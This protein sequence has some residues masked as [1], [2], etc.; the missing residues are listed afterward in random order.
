[1]SAD[2]ELG[3]DLSRLSDQFVVD[4]DNPWPGPPA[5]TESQAEFFRGRAEEAEHLLD[6]TKDAS[7]TLLYGKSG[8]GKTSLLQAGLF[9][10]LRREG[11][12]P[13]YKRLE[14]AREEDDYSKQILEAVISECER[15]EIRFKVPENGESL[16]EYFDP[17]QAEFWSPKGRPL[18]PVIVLDQFEELFTRGLGADPN[19]YEQFTN[20]L[21]ELIE[22]RPP[23]AVALRERAL[24]LQDLEQG[25]SNRP[26]F[27]RERRLCRV[28]LA[29]RA[30][31]L[32]ALETNLASRIPSL[33]RNRYPLRRMSGQQAYDAVMEVGQHL[34]EN[35]VTEQIIR[36]VTRR[37]GTSGKQSPEE[38]LPL[39]ELDV[40]PAILSIFCRELNEARKARGLARIS[41]AL[42]AQSREEIIEN[43]YDR[44]FQGLPPAREEP[45]RRFVEDKLQTGGYRENVD[46][47]RA[48]EE[49]RLDWETI[50]ELVE[51]RLVRIDEVGDGRPSRIEL[52]HDVLAGV[53]FKR[54]LKWKEAEQQRKHTREAEERARKNRNRLLALLSATV[55][56]TITALAAI[57]HFQRQQ[58]E[59]ERR[60]ADE[61][62]AR[63]AAEASTRA[64]QRASVE[65]AVS[66]MQR[67]RDIVYVLPSLVYAQ[68]KDPEDHW[69]NCRLVTALTQNTFLL[70]ASPDIGFAQSVSAAAIS[71]DRTLLVLGGDN[72]RAAVL[73]LNRPGQGL[74]ELKQPHGSAINAV[75]CHGASLRVATASGDGVKIW[76]AESG[77]VSE[78]GERTAPERQE[79]P[80]TLAFS[81]NGKWLLAGYHSG[82]VVR[83][84]PESGAEIESMTFPDPVLGMVI[85]PDDQSVLIYGATEG[86]HSFA[87]LIRLKEESFASESE[88][89]AER[90]VDLE[91]GEGG[92]FLTGATFLANETDSYILGLIGLSVKH[93]VG[94]WDT[95]S[96][97]MML[98]GTAL[99]GRA[100]WI[101]VS[102]DGNLLA[103]SHEVRGVDTRITFWG[104]D[105]EKEEFAPADTIDL[106]G[107]YHLFDF[108]PDSKLLLAAG[109]NGLVRIY[110]AAAEHSEEARQALDLQS[111]L[112]LA[113]FL[114]DSQTIVTVTSSGQIALWDIRVRQIA[115]I[116][117]EEDGDTRWTAFAG[118]NKIVMAN[119]T[120]LSEAAIGSPS[121]IPAKTGEIGDWWPGIMTGTISPDHRLV[122]GAIDDHGAYLGTV[123]NLVTNRVGEPVKL[124]DR[125][126]GEESPTLDATQ[127]QFQ[128]QGRWLLTVSKQSDLKLWQV[129]GGG[130][131]PFTSFNQ[132]EVKAWTATFHGNECLF[133]DA[134]K[135]LRRFRLPSGKEI[136][137]PP[138]AS[139]AGKLYAARFSAD[140]SRILLL[141]EN[142]IEVCRTG[143]GK[144]TSQRDFGGELGS[145]CLALSPNGRTAAVGSGSLTWLW[146][147]DSGN[148]ICN[149]LQL[150]GVVTALTFSDDGNSLLS[151]ETAN[152]EERIGFVELWDS[153]RGWPLAAPFQLPEFVRSA[154]FDPTGTR[155]VAACGKGSSVLDIAPTQP[156]PPHHPLLELAE[157]IAGRTA[158]EANLEVVTTPL[159][160]DRYLAIRRLREKM[161]PMAQQ[162]DPYARLGLWLTDTSLDS[163]SPS[164]FQPQQPDKPLPP[165]LTPEER[166][167]HKP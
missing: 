161:K 89:S 109:R 129:D 110:D 165:G 51:K 32:D 85:G 60:A 102:S 137:S 56:V 15:G 63:Q 146:Q 1:V 99:K 71:D 148:L 134:A 160:Q 95:S 108:S 17:I 45:A 12:L 86:A 46:V 19:R 94:G 43:F 152:T 153:A 119:S 116:R 55:L 38:E 75:A 136:T 83:F 133:L 91:T 88:D 28:V 163:R 48:L 154:A 54:Q 97:R 44:A 22:N 166:I 159:H 67:T 50:G 66:T 135:K 57:A 76:S 147:T 101:Q 107:D 114:S 33:A 155:F 140:G 82:K 21:A 126:S 34:I 26:H 164:P 30:D 7:L 98:H 92:L 59:A 100:K 106:T 145:A 73:H 37:A 167:D 41:A 96:G 49:G 70:P 14:H 123:W 20:E 18:I 29:L 4:R 6:L 104:I 74:V 39:P 3:R 103:S 117:I 69:V 105:R 157:V 139:H 149:P 11:F 35:G 143:D 24:R 81:H 150:Q 120:G 151:R 9:P 156:I 141:G 61:L 52:T 8:M 42:V 112:R 113:K 27:S 53:A 90:R 125:S 80:G 84:A 144:C 132:Q 36:S 118:D 65:R 72:G 77:K 122:F 10:L 124:A 16:W 127:A 131:S 58:A 13:I 40:E 5:F 25:V 121:S 162:G 138:L 115:P 31:F 64:L 111:N 23:P 78:L 130:I 47:S 87:R 93:A 158:R 142:S 68:R 62:K 2:L 128:T 79:S